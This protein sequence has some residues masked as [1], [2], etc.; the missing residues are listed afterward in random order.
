MAAFIAKEKSVARVVLFSSP[1]DYTS[2]MRS[3][4]PWI[5]MPSVTPPDRWYAEYHAKEKTAGMI[6]AAYKVLRIPTEHVQI[7]TLGLPPGMGHSSENPFHG[8]TIRVAGYET[9]WRELYGHSP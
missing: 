9:Q 8:S 6:A 4:A 5:A 3:L 2:R 1:W 7:F